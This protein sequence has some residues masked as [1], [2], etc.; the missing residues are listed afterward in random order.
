MGMRT[1]VFF[2]KSVVVRNAFNGIK[3]IRLEDGLVTTEPTA[4]KA[5]CVDF[6]TSLFGSSSSTP[7]LTACIQSIHPF[8]C[9]E[10]QRAGLEKNFTALEIKSEFFALPRDKAPGP[11]GF[12][13]EF[14]R[15]C[16]D[17]V[18][19]HVTVAI[20]SFFT[21]GKLEPSWN[22]TAVTM[23]AKVANAERVSEF[24]HIS[25]LNAVYKVIAKLL[26]RRLQNLLPEMIQV[27]QTAF[28]KDRQIVENVLL[29][30]ELVQGYNKSGISKRGML[31]IDLQKAFDSIE[32]SFVLDILAATG[33][34]TKYIQWISQCI[35]TTRFSIL[36]NG[37][38]CG[39]F[40]GKKGLRQGDPLSPYLFV[41]GMDI[42]S[43][44]LDLRFQSGQ[45]GY[46]PKASNPK[47][48]HLIFADDVMVFFDGEHSSLQAIV[49][50]LDYFSNISGLVMNRNK[51]DLFLAGT[52]MADQIMLS[53]GFGF[54]LG[55][56]PVRYLGLPLLPNALTRSDCEP[57]VQKVKK[58]CSLGK[59]NTFLTQGDFNY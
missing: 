50:L 49:N 3:R 5:A 51:T 47:V 21:Y 53:T 11:D 29:A 1:Q 6:Y 38:L 12:T 27:N 37:E 54:S 40:K 42:F 23:I 34:P 59:T 41:I 24:R 55:A 35:K 4:I 16:W 8:R 15:H 45:I 13:G 25:C 7:C 19:E 46:H 20:Q 28:V 52:T 48:S 33:F 57:L 30:S 22:S 10:S 56:L 17:I 36:V 2:H 18:G 43:R 14:F 31:K 26:A 44:L 9:S 58:G 32:W 39:Y